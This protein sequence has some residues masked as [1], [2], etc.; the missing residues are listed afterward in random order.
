[1]QQRLRWCCCEESRDKR[2]KTQI[3]RHGLLITAGEEAREKSKYVN[4]ADLDG[5]VL[6][7]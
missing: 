6:I 7:F 1:M 3:Q 4:I 2:T 5:V